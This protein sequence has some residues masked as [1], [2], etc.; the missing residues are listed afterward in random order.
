MAALLIAAAL[1]ACARQPPAGPLPA[2]VAKLLPN[3]HQVVAAQE[4]HMRPGGDASWAILYTLPNPPSAPSASPRYNASLSIADKA[5]SGWMLA[6]T[7]G[8]LGPV[9]AKLQ[10]AN[11]D[12][13]PAAAVSFGIGANSSG[14]WLVR[15][16]GVSYAV[17]YDGSGDGVSLQDLSSDGTPEVVRDWSPF[18]Q[19][20]VA[21]PR[22]T[23]VY[24]FQ[25]DHY[26]AATSLFPQV[27][28]KDAAGFNAALTRAGDPG[29]T[30]AWKPAD[31]ACLHGA[32]AF[33]ARE[34]SRPAEA[35]AQLAQAKQLNPAY[36]I[37][38]LDKQAG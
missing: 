10:L 3:G 36:D 37:A 16:T 26:V 32:L 27:I 13:L 34:L 9:G 23:T 29:T 24:T 11:V 8:E 17:I 25:G 15:S 12:N 7:I 33:L 14:L 30:P 38:A 1:S 5:P 35:Q 4:A 22:L 19:S 21:S 18:C 31:K 2:D 20:H 6:K 28:A